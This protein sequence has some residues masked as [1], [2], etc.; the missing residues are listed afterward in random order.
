MA[1]HYEGL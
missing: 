1:N